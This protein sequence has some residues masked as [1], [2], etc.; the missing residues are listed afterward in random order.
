MDLWKA[1]D[2][3]RRDVVADTALADADLDA[4]RATVRS[5]ID[6]LRRTGASLPVD[7]PRLRHAEAKERLRR[8][9]SGDHGGDVLAR[10]GAAHA[11][12]DLEADPVDE[13]AW[14]L[15]ALALADASVAEL[16]L[17]LHL[18]AGEAQRKVGDL[19]AARAQLA[20][21]TALLDRLG[22]DPYDGMLTDAYV[23]LRARIDR[24]GELP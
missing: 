2:R 23:R 11:L 19:P 16:R 3:R 7:E 9:W 1:S 20:A 12:A 18:N 22:T 8:I 13:L 6:P 15:R 24:D 5:L 17:S 21:G 10:L 4:A 14:D